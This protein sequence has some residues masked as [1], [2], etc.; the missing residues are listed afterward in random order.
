ME[1]ESWFKKAAD[2][3]DLYAQRMVKKS[4]T[5]Y[6]GKY[7]DDMSMQ[8]YDDNGEDYKMDMGYMDDEGYEE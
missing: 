5:Y 3:G 1:A 8:D 7:S 2:S 6:S 4:K